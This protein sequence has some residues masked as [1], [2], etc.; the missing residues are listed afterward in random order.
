MAI[1]LHIKLTIQVFSRPLNAFKDAKVARPYT[2]DPLW[3]KLVNPSFDF[4]SEA[5]AI[6]RIIE[7]YVVNCVAA[8]FKIVREVPHC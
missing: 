3:S 6:I 5:A 4:R 1:W 2:D 8:G 7:R